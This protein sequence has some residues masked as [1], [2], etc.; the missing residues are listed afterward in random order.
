[1]KKILLCEIP[2]QICTR[3][4]IRGSI[5]N[6][7]IFYS[8]NIVVSPDSA[9]KG[10]A[11]PVT[12]ML[13]LNFY[14]WFGKKKDLQRKQSWRRRG[15]TWQLWL[16][17]PAPSWT[18]SCFANFWEYLHIQP[19]R[20]GRQPP[21]PPSRGITWLR[22]VCPLKG[23]LLYVLYVHSRCYLFSDISNDDSLQIFLYHAKS[24]T[25]KTLWQEIVYT[26]K[27]FLITKV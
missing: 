11:N 9:F 24:E 6:P 3:N 26:I 22:C 5:S 23:C 19:Q 20:E 4:R 21:D 17:S 14:L 10:N 25:V 13:L 16:R 8:F 2:R 18:P 1:M 7:Y 12:R 15:D 27:I